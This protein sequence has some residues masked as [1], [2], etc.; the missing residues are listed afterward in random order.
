MEIKSRLL[1][2]QHQRLQRILIGI[3]VAMMGLVVLGGLVPETWAAGPLEAVGTT[4]TQHGETPWYV[5]GF[6]FMLYLPALAGWIAVLSKPL[7]QVTDDASASRGPDRGGS[8]R[9]SKP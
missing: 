6:A 9:K 3:C 2:L 1:N 4:V 7:K 8:N 5:S